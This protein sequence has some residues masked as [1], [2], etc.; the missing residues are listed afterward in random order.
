LRIANDSN[1]SKLIIDEINNKIHQMETLFEYRSSCTKCTKKINL[2]NNLM[3]KIDEFKNI[4][5]LELPV[6]H[7]ELC[8]SEESI[9]K[10]IEINYNF[11]VKYKN[12]F[13]IE[14]IEGLNDIYL[15]SPIYDQEEIV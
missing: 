1:E 8:V 11:S 2:Y 5:N 12:A 6:Y 15:N 9:C 14:Y 10:Q 4:L 7:K 3:K 13:I